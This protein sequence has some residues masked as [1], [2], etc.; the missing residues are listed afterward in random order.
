[1][2][3]FVVALLLV[4]AVPAGAHKRFAKKE[5][6]KCAECHMNPEGGGAR[7]IIGQYY[8]AKG[9]LPLD[10]TPQTMQ[11][12]QDTVDRWMLDVMARPPVIR[13]RRTPL[14]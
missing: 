10:R 8:Q 9:E 14:S 6:V 2:R 7:N 1:M 13:F 4:A 11:L 3:L 12:V 5:G